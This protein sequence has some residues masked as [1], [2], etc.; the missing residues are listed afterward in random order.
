MARIRSTNTKPELIV[1]QL[2]HRM[3][4]RF[5]IH[6][7]DLPGSPDI[8]FTKRKRAIFVH[9]CFWHQH[10]GCKAAHI[11]ETGKDYWTA[12]FDR[13]KARDLRKETDIRALGWTPIIVWECETRNPNV[14]GER[15][16]QL[17]GPPRLEGR[18]CARLTL[19]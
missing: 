16:Q 9:G 12:K 13:N 15:L 11:P 3:G 2:L 6:H 4:Y 19:D 14:L 5:R 8:V 7:R 10:D 17:L 1:R 18:H